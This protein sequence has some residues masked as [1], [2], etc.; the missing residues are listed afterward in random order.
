[1]TPRSKFESAQGRATGSSFITD[2]PVFRL[3]RKAARLPE[4]CRLRET[5]KW[6]YVTSIDPVAPD[7][8]D[9]GPARC[10]TVDSADS[11]YL[12]EGMVPTHNT[13]SRNGSPTRPLADPERTRRDDSG[14]DINPK[15]GQSLQAL[16]DTSAAPTSSW[17]S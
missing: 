16:V 2:L 8:P 10:I 1:M 7:D 6:L 5:Q 11:T 3:P 13:L 15:P 9:Y 14:R 17:T 12:V 4:P